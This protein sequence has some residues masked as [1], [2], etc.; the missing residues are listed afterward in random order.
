MSNYRTRQRSAFT[1]V[2]LLVVIGIIAVLIG[3][4]LPALQRAR[5]SANA[6]KCA[7]NLRSIGQGLSIY[8]AENKGTYPAAYIYNG[9]RINGTLGGQG[10]QVPDQALDGYLHWS[11]FLY[12]RKDVGNRNSIFNGTSGW[13]AFACPSLERGGLPPTNTYT[14]NNDPGQQP[15]T[16]NVIDLQS[17]R[18]AYTV[19]EAIMPRNKFVFG[20]QGDT[21]RPYQFVRASQVRKTAETVLATE[22]NSDWRIVADSGRG[23]PG[24][25]VCKSHRP[26]HGFVGLTGE[27]NMEKVAPDAFGRRPAYRRV[28][29]SDLTGDPQ[30]GQQLNTRLDWVG[31]NHDRKV[32]KGGFDIR[33]SNFLFCDGHVETKGILDTLAPTFQWGERF[34]SLTVNGDVQPQ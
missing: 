9:M 34:Y 26:I 2:E 19:N 30:V 21:V 4:L 11:S 33:R 8:V 10:T 13:D 16:A 23:D 5:E 14:T 25:T 1:L 17:P 15:D 20:F 22:W 7:S 32:L 28:T 18:C 3:I 12:Q 24:A 31:R 29:T 6:L 27:Q